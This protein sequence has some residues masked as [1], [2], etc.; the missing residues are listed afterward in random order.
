[1][2]SKHNW[3]A[4]ISAFLFWDSEQRD[5]AAIALAD[6]LEDAGHLS[7]ANGLREKVF[8][9]Y[10]TSP[11]D[12]KLLYVDWSVCQTPEQMK[13]VA[14]PYQRVFLCRGEMEAYLKGMDVERGEYFHSETMEELTYL[15]SE[16]R[17]EQQ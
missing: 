5:F 15:V 3:A 4:V 2:N 7:A 12:E 17:W 1:M 9:I 16:R 14:E 11:Q 13:T 8:R 10:V 6:L